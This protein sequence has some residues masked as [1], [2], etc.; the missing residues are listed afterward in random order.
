MS[1]SLYT[2]VFV[3]VSSSNG[4]KTNFR[5]IRQYKLILNSQHDDNQMFVPSPFSSS[6]V[7]CLHFIIHFVIQHLVCD[8]LSNN[9]G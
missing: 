9:H 2:Y 6:F 8:S 7:T 5:T 4:Y 1:S 3:F